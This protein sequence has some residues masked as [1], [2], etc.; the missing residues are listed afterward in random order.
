MK[1]SVSRHSRPALGLAARAALCIAGGA[2]M[3]VNVQTFVHTGELL[4]GGFVGL[5][6]LIRDALAR[7]A[8]VRV[9][10]GLLYILLNAVPVVLSW[11]LVGRRYTALS[12][13]SILVASVLTA[14]LPERAV[15][16][17]RVLVSVFGGLVQGLSI[18]ICLQARATSGGTDFVA[19]L[20]ARRWHVDG[21]WAV[22][23]FNAA[24]LLC[25]GALF[26]WEHALWS[27]VFQFVSTQTIRTYHT[28][29]KR[30]TVLAVTDRPEEVAE[31]IRRETRHGATRVEAAGAYSGTPHRL[32]YSVVDSDEVSAVVRGI[33]EI[34]PKSFVNAFR[35]DIVSGHWYERPED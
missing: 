21:W 7:F 22:L 5:G 27:I 25:A 4:P 31:F 16:G 35:T 12:F 29:Y 2:I 14:V 24:V 18:T 9:P 20:L 26:G 3:A 13:L 15:V 28:R 34:D 6:L 23:Y 19:V 17:D 10:F 30:H 32:V 33:R 8:G 11:R 1:V